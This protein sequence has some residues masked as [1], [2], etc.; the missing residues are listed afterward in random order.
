LPQTWIRDEVDGLDRPTVTAAV[1]AAAPAVIVHQMT[2]LAD[3][4]GLRQ[5]D[6]VFAG[7]HELRT[8]GT[9]NLLAAAAEAG[10]R[11]VVA[12]RYTRWTR[13]TRSTRLPSRRRGSRWWRSGTWSGLFRPACRRA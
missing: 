10:P 8:T 6:R 3:M 5:F 9:D 13:A 2:A 7:A 11:R 1:R 4:C 12:Q